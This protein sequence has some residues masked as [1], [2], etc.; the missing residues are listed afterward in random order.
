MSILDNSE[1]KAA[2]TADVQTGY[3][4]LPAGK[5]AMQLIELHRHTSPSGS[6]SL[7]NV[8]RI[9]DGQKNGGRLFFNYASLKPEHIGRVRGIYE[10]VG[11][12]LTA[13]ED[14]IVGRS[15][16]V[17]VGVEADTRPDHLGEFQNKVKL[18]TKYDGPP[19]PQYID[20]NAGASDGDDPDADI[21]FGVGGSEED[22][23]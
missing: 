11:A 19:L 1:Q 9:A 23:V 18:I 4:A 5:Y 7:K 10:A 22:L 17:T 6:E 8:W 2:A 12:P 21:P 3:E 15:A 20:P 16:W 13:D 14:D